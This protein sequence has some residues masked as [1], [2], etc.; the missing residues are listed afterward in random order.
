METF[1]EDLREKHRN[2]RFQKLIGPKVSFLN[3]YIENRQGQLYTRVHRDPT[4]P[5]YILPYVI[6]HTKSSH[7]GHLFSALIRAVCYCT[8]VEDFHRER[9]YLELTYLINGYSLLFLE[10]H[11]KRFFNYFDSET[12]RFSYNQNSYDK[13]RQLWFQY[14]KQRQEQSS[15]LQKFDDTNCLY[16]FDYI[17][18]FGPKCRFNREF[19]QTWNHYFEHHPTLCEENCKI[20]LNAKNFHSLNSLLGMDKPSVRL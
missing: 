8:F 18:D 10:T 7:S 13:F 12:M 14:V 4:M 6:G 2:V 20:I 9:I 16:Q 3:A 1:L 5:R 19:R 15:Q 17:Y 11:V